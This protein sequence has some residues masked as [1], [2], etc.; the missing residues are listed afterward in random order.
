MFKESSKCMVIPLPRQAVEDI[1]RITQNNT[2]TKSQL[3]RD[4]L[5]HYM[6]TPPTPDHVPARA[7]R[8]RSYW[9]PLSTY[10]AWQENA[11]HMGVSFQL[12]VRTAIEHWLEHLNTCIAENESRARADKAVMVEYKK[13]LDSAP[14]ARNPLARALYKAGRYV[15][16]DSGG[17]VIRRMSNRAAYKWAAKRG[18]VVEVE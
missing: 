10:Q 4:A 15:V 17:R 18:L 3:V 8:P 5:D 13:E 7:D 6:N 9:V 12:A 16:K 2:L 14:R 1:E 11:R